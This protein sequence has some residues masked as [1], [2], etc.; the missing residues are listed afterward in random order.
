MLEKTKNAFSKE[1][2]AMLKGLALIFMLL[3]HLFNRREIDGLYD[4][5]LYTKGGPLLVYLTFACDAVIPIFC[6]V[7]G[8]GLYLSQQKKGSIFAGNLKRIFRFLSD[9]WIILIVFSIV[10]VIMHSSRLPVN[11]I[12]FLGNASTVFISY[13]G[14]WWYVPQYVILVVVSP[15]L[16]RLVKRLPFW[17]VLAVSF[18]L[19]CVGYAGGIMDVLPNVNMAT[20]LFYNFGRCQFPF[21]IGVIFANKNVFA[22]IDVHLSKLSSK[23]RNLVCILILIA[24]WALRMLVNSLFLSV[25]SAV[26]IIIAF[27]FLSKA[28]PIKWLLLFL[29]GH[30]TNVWLIHMFF[31]QILFSKLVFYPQ[32]PIVIFLWLLLLCIAASYLIKGIKYCLNYI[33]D[34]TKKL[35]RKEPA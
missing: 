27:V 23:L 30:S 2:S 13:C 32:I 3:L 18:A 6:F 9:Y 28:K 17:A 15:L 34:K 10:G 1:E 11:F 4:V 33:F 24:T 19:Y 20:V 12:T 29:S 8:Y 16:I 25:F 7:S 26:F 21:L 31:Y 14:A 35:V 5:F 22:S